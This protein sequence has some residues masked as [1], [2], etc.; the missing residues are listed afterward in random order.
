MSKNRAKPTN[1]ALAGGGP[2]SDEGVQQQFLK[3]ALQQIKLSSFSMQRALD[4]NKL[5]DALK[6]ASN[7]VSELRTGLLTPKNYYQLY[8][9]CF[10]ELRHLGQYLADG[11]HE[12]KMTEL[13]ELVQY[14][15]NILPRLYLLITV[16]AVYVK[17]R[18]APAKDVL[19]DL[20]EMCRGVQHPTRGLFLRTYLSEMT[21][22]V[23][24]DVPPGGGGD[25][26]AAA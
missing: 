3:E 4:M 16:G 2:P 11:R 15:G 20:V 14:A 18:E 21:K 1:S 12:R 5:M 26:A 7:L 13:Y 17:K 22:D 25:A 6:H 19:R 24:P 9:A 8:M 10:D 23:L